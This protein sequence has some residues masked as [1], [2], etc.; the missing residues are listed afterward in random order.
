M[1]FLSVFLRKCGLRLNADFFNLGNQGTTSGVLY[2]SYDGMLE[3]LGQSQVL[4][5]LKRLAADR[6][7]HLISFE[8]AD[9]WANT[10]ERER[11]PQGIAAAG[12]IWHPL[13]YHKRPTAVATA[14]NI[15]CGITLGHCLFLR[16]RLAIVHARS[17]V[18]A[19]MALALKRLTVV[20][21][22]FYISIL[23]G[24]LNLICPKCIVTLK[25]MM[26]LD[27]TKIRVG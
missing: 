24:K 7:I 13:R 12:I 6:P 25:I 10:T 15:A 16:Y 5:Y 20:K 9:D 17:Y 8:K 27:A 18:P 11:I 23:L 21:F 22:L 19:V 3:P 4:A 14:W 1:L 2:I 26:N